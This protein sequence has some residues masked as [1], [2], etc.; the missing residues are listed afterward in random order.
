[1][2]AQLAA[3][4]P[5]GLTGWAS[6][7]VPQERVSAPSSLSSS[8]SGSAAGRA[9]GPTVPV[10]ETGLLLLMRLLV[11][12]A[13][14]LVSAGAHLRGAPRHSFVGLAWLLR[15]LRELA[16][17]WP[18]RE[19]AVGV[20]G[21]AQPSAAISEPGSGPSQMQGDMA[22]AVAASNAEGSGLW[23]RVMSLVVGALTGSGVQLGIGRELA[24]LLAALHAYNLAPLPAPAHQ[25]L[26]APA[27]QAGDAAA[28]VQSGLVPI[29]LSPPGAGLPSLTAGSQAGGMSCPG[30]YLPVSTSQPEQLARQQMVAQCLKQASLVKGSAAQ[31]FSGRTL[32]GAVQSMAESL[33][34]LLGLPCPPTLTCLA[35]R[36]LQSPQVVA[37]SQAARDLGLGVLLGSSEAPPPTWLVQPTIPGSQPA[38]PP[39]ELLL[40]QPVW[41]GGDE[42][43][44]GAHLWRQLSLLVHGQERA[45]RL[46]HAALLGALPPVVAT[47]DRGLSSSVSSGGGAPVTSIPRSPCMPPSS[48]TMMGLLDSGPGAPPALAAGS[49]H[50]GSQLACLQRLVGSLGEQVFHVSCESVGEAG[51]L[52]ALLT[53]A[54]LAAE[55]GAGAAQDL[56]GLY[57]LAAL[58][59]T[60]SNQQQGTPPAAAGG[61][62]GAGAGVGSQVPPPSPGGPLA[63]AGA[64]GAQSLLGPQE[65][66]LALMVLDKAVVSAAT[67]TQ[68]RGVGGRGAR[69]APPQPGGGAWGEAGLLS[70]QLGKAVTHVLRHLVDNCSGA[71]TAGTAPAVQA[72]AEAVALLAPLLGHLCDALDRLSRASSAL[73]QL[74][75]PAAAASVA[76]QT[77]QATQATQATFAGGSGVSADLVLRHA[78][79]RGVRTAADMVASHFITISQNANDAAHEKF[80]ANMSVSH[81][82][83]TCTACRFYSCNTNPYMPCLTVNHQKS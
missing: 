4:Y 13:T 63:S 25:L 12:T 55:V 68:Q 18:A 9:G 52:A 69:D 14:H 28:A 39:A 36:P 64:A 58:T 70:E 83:T 2:A 54:T 42:D 29:L 35:A 47:R 67:Q 41:C 6:S 20:E 5:H 48:L 66:Q 3:Q 62:Q 53:T 7:R 34:A 27:L 1:V 40:P 22:A 21:G 16:A 19:G 79:V 74:V 76:A 38:L 15:A 46:R 32:C 75:H 43:E 78:G 37:H 60:S 59:G 23:S 30:P 33:L 10:M 77:Q 57:T 51:D 56:V 24:N 71:A 80:S 11:S 73:A 49:V 81:T 82:A 45:A 31:A 72:S 61:S 8:G 26:L 50:R 44:G 17:A 65:H